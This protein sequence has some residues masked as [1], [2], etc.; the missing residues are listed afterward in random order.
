MMSR[1]T[2]RKSI[3]TEADVPVD[4]IKVCMS[5]LVDILFH[6]C[7]L[8]GL[9]DSALHTLKLAESLHASFPQHGAVLECLNFTEKCRRLHQELELFLHQCLENSNELSGHR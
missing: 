3:V 2:N 7:N 1:Y 8:Q 6:I 5:V 9:R 4:A